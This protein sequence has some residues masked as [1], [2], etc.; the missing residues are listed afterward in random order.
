QRDLLRPDVVIDRARRVGIGFAQLRLQP[1]RAHVRSARMMHDHPLISRAYCVARSLLGRLRYYRS[2]LYSVESPRFADRLIGILWRRSWLG[3]IA[4]VSK[5]PVLPPSAAFLAEYLI[6]MLRSVS[7]TAKL[8]MVMVQPPDL[9]R[10][11]APVLP[12]AGFLGNVLFQ[13]NTATWLV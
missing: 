4:Y 1:Y 3:R 10:A 6:E 8:R 5:G 11:F 9:D 2:L 7:R 12:A 13:F